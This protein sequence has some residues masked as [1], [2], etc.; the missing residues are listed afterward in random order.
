MF[1]NIEAHSEGCKYI[2]ETILKG[3]LLFFSFESFLS[4]FLV[5]FGDGALIGYFLVFL[6]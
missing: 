5:F 2:S 4:G 3:F 6:F 1:V